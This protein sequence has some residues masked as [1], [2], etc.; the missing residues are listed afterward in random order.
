MSQMNDRNYML[1]NEKVSKV[2]MKLSLPA[3]IGMIVNALYNVVDT[4]FIGR[5]VGPMAIGG[6]AIAFP[7]QMFIMAIAQMIGIGA[8]SMISRSLGAGDVEKRITL[9]AM[10]TFLSSLLP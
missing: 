5:G 6:L 8:A 2:L 3:T 4:I 7:I 9:Q 1:A 10:P